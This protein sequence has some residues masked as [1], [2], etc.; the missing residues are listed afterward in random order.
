VNEAADATGL[1]RTTIYQALHTINPCSF[2]PPLHGKRAG[3]L[4]LI[5]ARE[6]ERWIDELPDV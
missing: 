2:P 6:L 4:Y 1:S 5:P 3:R